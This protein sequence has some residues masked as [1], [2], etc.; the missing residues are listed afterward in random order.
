MHEGRGIEPWTVAITFDD[1]YQDNYLYAHPI[2]RRYGL[3]A[4]LFVATGYIGTGRVLW[5]DRVAWAIKHTERNNTEFVSRFTG[6][7]LPLESMDD[8]NKAFI[9]ILENLKGYPEEE[10]NALVDDIVKELQNGKRGP[11]PM[12]LS[13]G[14]LHTM[15][16][17]GWA[18]GSHTVN[19]AILT[20]VNEAGARRE[21]LESKQILEETLQRAVRLFAYPNGRDTD[22]NPRIKALIRETGYEAAVTTVDGFNEANCDL[23]EIR[24]RNPWDEHL[25]SFVFKL[26]WSYWNAVREPSGQALATGSR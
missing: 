7:G 20:K 12:M 5:N 26:R 4:T 10:R 2:L 24:R 21:L 23:F 19:H 1:G 17:E 11:E 22:F 6:E 3:P 18:V 14:E 13:W 8:R 25:S 9:S 15:T 16:Q